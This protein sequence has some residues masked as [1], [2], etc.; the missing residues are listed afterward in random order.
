M[1]RAQRKRG[2]KT[3]RA[4][5]VK[6]REVPIE[7]LEAILDKAKTGPLPEAE[8]ATLKAAVDTLAK[9]TEELESKDTSLE[10]LRRLIFGARTETTRAVLGDSASA[11]TDDAEGDDAAE[12]GTAD[13][14]SRR[15]SGT[16]AS[17]RKPRKG[18]G[19]NG[20]AAYPTAKRVA[21]PHATLAHADPCP[22]LGCEGGRLYLQRK[23][24]AVMV[25]VTGVAPLDATVY[26]RARLRCHLCGTVTTADAPEGV[27]TETYDATAAA[28]IALMK[29]GCGMPF[30]RLE[31]L[32]RNLG[33]PLPTSTQW[34]VVRGA[35][36]SAAPAYD[37][38]MRQGAQGAVLHNDDTHARILQLTAEARAEQLPKD[39]KADRSGVFTTGVVAET[40]AARIALFM[41]GPRHAGENLGRV[42]DQREDATPPIQMS[43]ALSRNAPTAHTTIEANCLPHARRKYVD[44]ASHFPEECRF[45]LETLREVFRIDR[46]SR[47]EGLSPE[48]RLALHQAQSTPHMAA[49]ESWMQQ[50]FDERRVEPNSGLGEAI[51]YM[52][53]H[54][55]KLTRFL[56][57]AGAPIDN[58]ICERALKRAILHR[59][60]A[61]FYRTLNGARVGDIF[62]SLI[63][64]AELN[65]VEP[66]DYLVAL[67]RHAAALLL[68]PAAW[69]P[70]T[71]IET[72]ANLERAPPSG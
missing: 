45:V 44:V 10:R 25:R 35:A 18:H 29:Y 30:H 70:W 7:Q 62:M 3:S 34:D 58:N 37:E 68:D 5:N 13:T 1:S 52:Q 51:R 71:Y 53:K 49:L 22:E 54:W 60:N 20:A 6:R 55:A 38:L 9:L 69:M 15:E 72:V 19:R 48:A 2:R 32:E 26:E 8:H 46:R 40:D 17:T 36:V 28:M 57:V 31:R 67:Q 61:M 27:G 12:A 11:S 23:Q 66:F 24:P 41:T 42:L 4:G 64:T 43:D 39:A 21:V 65:D 14:S 47:T 59:K 50:Q 63:H 56:Q 33:I 16:A